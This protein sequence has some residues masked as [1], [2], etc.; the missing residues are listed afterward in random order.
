M[1]A[2]GLIVEGTGRSAPWYH[3]RLSSALKHEPQRDVG[4][5]KPFDLTLE[6]GLC[7][8]LHTPAG[9]GLS[10]YTF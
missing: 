5:R 6:L 1:H 8:L 4:V 10:N 9:E 3:A 7:F 2:C